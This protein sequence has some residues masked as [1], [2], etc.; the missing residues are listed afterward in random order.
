MAPVSGSSAT[1]RTMAVICFAYCVTS[2]SMR[3]MRRLRPCQVFRQVSKA[4]VRQMVTA[5]GSD[6]AL[7]LITPKRMS[8]EQALEFISDD[9]LLEITPKSVRIRKRILDHGLRMREESK[10]KQD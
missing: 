1:V 2:S 9:E 10:K 3:G 4:S 7:R 6:E 5:A 8:L